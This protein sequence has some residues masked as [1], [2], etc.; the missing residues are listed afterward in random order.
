MNKLALDNQIC[1]PLYTASRLLSQ[2]YSP[3]L[4]PLN[5]TYPQYLVMMVLWQSD[6]VSLS[7][8]GK[9][10]MLDSGTLTPLLKK[11]EAQQLLTRE[12]AVEDERSLVVT[13]T[14]KG[15]ALQK[16]AEKVPD[17]M[18]C[19]LESL[20]HSEILQLHKLTRK[21]MSAL[22][23]QL[24]KQVDKKLDNQLNKQDLQNKTKILKVKNS[25]HKQNVTNKKL[26]SKR[27]KK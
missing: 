3:I 5:L 10:L 11:L 21:L 27:S 15:K 14:K 19:N 16:Q 8:I 12:R 2:I 25:I 17:L 9:L 26:N 23:T 4:A 6:S 22:A 1:F 24:N 13:L 20:E 18:I 7:E